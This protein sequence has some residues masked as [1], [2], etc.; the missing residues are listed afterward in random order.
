VILKNQGCFTSVSTAAVCILL[1]YSG[2][3]HAQG[4]VFFVLDASGSMGFQRGGMSRFDAAREQIRNSASQFEAQGFEMGLLAF[5][6]RTGGCTDIEV[7]VELKSSGAGARADIFNAIAPLSPLGATPLA[8]SIRKAGEY[9]QD[10]FNSDAEVVVVTDGVDT[11]SGDAIGAASALH[12][13]GI[14]LSIIGMDLDPGDELGLSQVAAAGGGSF[15]SAST[16][17]GMSP[18]APSSING[19]TYGGKPGIKGGAPNGAPLIPMKSGREGAPDDSKSIIDP[20]LVPKEVSFSREPSP[21]RIPAEIAPQAPVKP[22]VPKVIEKP[23]APLE[24]LISPLRL[25]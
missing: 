4:K 1:L 10:G 23:T 19:G 24:M 3:A 18:N 7:M 5:S 11:C 20:S 12:Q 17:G 6:H 16:P 21:V 14:K 8:A 22:P 2:V 25:I 9:L 15:R 13:R